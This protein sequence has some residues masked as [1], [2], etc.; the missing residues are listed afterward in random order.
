MKQFVI[1]QIKSIIYYSCNNMPNCMWINPLFC[2]S[3]SKKKPVH[4]NDQTS[5][6]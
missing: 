4:H 1:L 5:W 3:V 2:R 6:I